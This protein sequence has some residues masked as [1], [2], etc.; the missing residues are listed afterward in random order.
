MSTDELLSHAFNLLGIA[1]GPSA[2]IFPP[3]PFTPHH[4]APRTSPSALLR[5]T[6][7]SGVYVR[8]LPGEG[9]VLAWRAG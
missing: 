5:P 6:Q 8:D 2:V 7:T 1:D 3:R 9:G 4:F